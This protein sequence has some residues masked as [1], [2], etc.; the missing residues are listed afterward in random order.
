MTHDDFDGLLEEMGVILSDGAAIRC[1]FATT[2]K[3][4]SLSCGRVALLP[5]LGDWRV[6]QACVMGVGLGVVCVVEAWGFGL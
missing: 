3:G 6:V 4:L 5:R 1:R 2:P